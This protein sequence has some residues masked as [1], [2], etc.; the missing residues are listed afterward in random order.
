RMPI[1]AQA[2]STRTAISPRLATRIL[3]M[4]RVFSVLMDGSMLPAAASGSGG[5]QTQQEGSR[6]GAE[7]RAAER[8][9]VGEDADLVAAGGHL[10]AELLEVGDDGGRGSAV[11]LGAVERQPGAVPDQDAAAGG[12]D[13]G[14]Q[15]LGAA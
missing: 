5:D 12:G 8:P 11:D 14:A 9:A 3:R 4:G 6:G 15:G 13:L 10:D 7:Q 2:R 1:S